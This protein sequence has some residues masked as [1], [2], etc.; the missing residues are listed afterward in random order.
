[1]FWTKCNKLIFENGAPV[2]C[3]F[4]P[5]PGYGLF[6]FLI[7]SLSPNQPTG[8]PN[9]CYESCIVKPMKI[10]NGH[11]CYSDGYSGNVISISLHS[12]DSEGKVGY[13]KGCSG[14][15]EDCIDWDVQ[16]GDCID[17]QTYYED[18]QQ[19]RV[20]QILPCYTDYQLFKY[21]AKDDILII[22]IPRK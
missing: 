9:Y 19:I 8:T 17:W 1:M 12:P 13:Y 16:S 4:S 2:N 22:I 5:C 14:Q 7:R 21:V 15:W 20:Y 10:N 3:D 18:C 11:I 6:A